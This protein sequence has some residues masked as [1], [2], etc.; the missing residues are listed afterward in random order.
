L[1]QKEASR[2][3]QGHTAEQVISNLREAGV[4]QAKGMS[5]E[6][7]MRQLGI[8]DATYYKWRQENG[9]PGVDQANQLKELEQKNSRLWKVDSG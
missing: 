7:A 6:E 8:N 1:G 4:L 5:I 3:R 2:S 9:G